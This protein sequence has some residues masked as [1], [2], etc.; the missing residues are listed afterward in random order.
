[1]NCLDGTSFKILETLSRELGTEMS[2]N[3]LTERV[4]ESYGSAYYANIYNK[5]QQLAKENI[6]TINKI[7]NTSIAKLNFDDQWIVDVLAQMEMQ[8]KRAFLQE[9]ANQ[10]MHFLFPDL[11]RSFRDDLP[12][13]RSISVIRPEKNQLINRAELLILVKGRGMDPLPKQSDAELL[14]NTMKTLQMMQSLKIDYL[15]LTEVKF[16]DLIT[17]DEMNPAREMLAD[18]ITVFGPQNFWHAI[19]VIAKKGI[20]LKITKSETAP[21]KLAEADLVYNMAR[22][23][24][25][26]MG[27]RISQGKD[28]CIEYIIAAM[29]A[30]GNARRIEAVPVLLAK[31][32]VN[33]DALMFI[34]RKIKRSERLLGLLNVLADIIPEKKDV[35]YAIKVMKEMRI[36]AK[37][38]D[39]SSIL[40]K[41][42]LY[43]AT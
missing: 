31:N 18:K 2:I 13:V 6:V 3:Q 41:M 37:P 20:P 17:T 1:M 5:L 40:E 9:T 12:F 32:S 42:R 14:H 15:M 22:F 34:S 28:I 7:G 36:K 23:G 39:R 26:E 24:Y 4:R 10:A 16:L 21:P 11:E 27:T 43:N 29:M 30:Q 25:N 19:Q 35:E 38:A 8:K 33:Y